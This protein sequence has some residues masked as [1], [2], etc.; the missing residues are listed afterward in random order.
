MGTIDADAHVIESERTWDYIEDPRLRPRLIRADDPLGR[1][2]EWWLVDG[3]VRSKQINVGQ[4]T[5]VETREMVDIAARLRHMDALGID[6]Q[7]LYPTIFLEPLTQR[8]EVELALCRSY[9]RWLA[10]IWERSENRLRW[11]AVLPLLSMDAAL[12][13]LNVATRRGA[14][15]VFIRGVEGERRLVDPYFFPLYEE[16]SRLNVPICVHAATGH[17][18]LFAIWQGECGFTQF[19]IP[20]ISAFHSLVF[21]EI[22]NRF[23]ELRFGFIEVSSQWVPYVMRDMAKR[24]RR[25]GKQLKS[26]LLRANRMYVACQTDDDLPYVLQYAGED[27]LVIGTD[28]GHADNSAEIEALRHLKEMGEV[29][30][31]V[32]DKILYDNPRALYAL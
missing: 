6:V 9:N 12:D 26:D 2:S 25:R 31:Q 28:Y 7:V 24:F 4:E 21:G 15:A 32:I 11:A 30:P 19:K 23:P 27:N 22:P 1:E 29:S 3:M 5:T 16:A 14:C 8:P 10:D 17:P 13:E 20:C 18:D